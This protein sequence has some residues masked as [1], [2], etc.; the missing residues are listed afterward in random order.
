MVS[1]LIFSAIQQVARII[2][3][4]RG[5]GWAS[6]GGGDKGDF[7]GLGQWGTG[8]GAAGR[9]GW[10]SEGGGNLGNRGWGAPVGEDGGD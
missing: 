4:D 8:E 7:R 6:G 5:W 2:G 1:Q 10:D 3:P 9:I